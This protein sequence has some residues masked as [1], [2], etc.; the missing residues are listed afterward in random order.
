MS[1]E[2]TMFT[3]LNN[4]IDE[5]SRSIQTLNN[6]LDQYTKPIEPPKKYQCTYCNGQGWYNDGGSKMGI[7]IRCKRCNQTGITDFV[8]VN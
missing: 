1:F 4:K 8:V 3:I 6:K 2:N 7:P 5:L